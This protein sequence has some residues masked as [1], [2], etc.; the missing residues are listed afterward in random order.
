MSRKARK[1][2]PVQEAPEA[3]PPPAP[4]ETPAV[5]SQEPPQPAPEP[6]PA[7]S[8]PPETQSPQPAVTPQSDEELP[9]PPSDMAEQAKKYPALKTRRPGASA[10][11]KR[12]GAILGKDL[13]TMGKHGLVSS[14]IVFVVLM[15]VFT[16]ASYGMFKVVS[17]TMG[18]GNGDG[19]GDGGDGP[20]LSNDG[21]LVAHAGDDMTVTAGTAVTLDS[22]ATVNSS[23]IMYIEWR[24]IG[25]DGQLLNEVSLYGSPATFTFNYVGMYEVDLSVVDAKFN[26]DDDNFT[27]TV[28]RNGGDT[29]PPVINDIKMSPNGS[30]ESLN[31]GMPVT[32]DATNSTDNVG[33][34]NYTWVFRDITDVYRYGPV[35]SYTFQSAGDHQAV[36]TVRD[37]AGNYFRQEGPVYVNPNGP[38]SQWP[39]GQIGDLPQSVNIGDDVQLGVVNTGNNSGMM[40]YFWIISLNNSV[41][42]MPGQEV[43]FTAKGFGMYQIVLVIRDSAGNVATDE[44]NVLSLASGMKA[45]SAVNWMS[46][47]FQQ[48]IPLNVLTFVYGAALLACIVFVGGLF[49][50]G[51][52]HEIDKGTAKTLFFAPVSVTNLVFAKILYPLLLAPI[53]IFPLMLISTMPLGQ[54]IQQVFMITLVSFVMTAAVLASAAYGSCMIYALTKRMSIKPTSLAR[55]FMYLSI[56]STL[57]VFVGVAFAMNEFMSFD[58]W[59][60]STYQT[61]GTNFAMFSPFHQAGMLIKNMLLGTTEPLDLIVFV[62]P[63][64]LIAGGVAASRRLFPDIYGRE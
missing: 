8:A 53:F 28:N 44:R 24:I 52:K 63:A 62:I 9:P 49:S 3:P 45:P 47:P 60:M 27:V 5:V 34:V 54:D 35:V 40:E 42:R 32:L 51:F 57:A 20:Q 61:L 29:Q 23:S 11:L 37:A 43:S 33:V 58:L 50:K 15:V 64:V 39:Q 46:T 18:D 48:D 41:T 26:F 36:V 19:N 1:E 7:P 16:I 55:L 2:K 14:I 59:G 38:S 17:T 56:I 21:S 31:Y 12:T 25:M 10:A 30:N 6:E 13:R 22:S 4:E